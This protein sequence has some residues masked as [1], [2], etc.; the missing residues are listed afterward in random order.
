MHDIAFAPR[1]AI[2]RAELR[3]AV[4]MGIDICGVHAGRRVTDS[5]N[6][7]HRSPRSHQTC[8]TLT[9]KTRQL[10]T[11]LVA[12]ATLQRTKFLFRQNQSRPGPDGYI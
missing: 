1:R 11:S 12:A 6:L 2:I 10:P 8:V 5:R 7:R 4:C 3:K 9:Q